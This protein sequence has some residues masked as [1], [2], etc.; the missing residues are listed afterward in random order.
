MIRNHDH[1][2]RNAP[3]TIGEADRDAGRSG[4]TG[5]VTRLKVN[6][7]KFPCAKLASFG[8]TNDAGVDHETG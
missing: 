4:A 6:T 7:Y 2:G 1:P 3:T 8:L 5:V